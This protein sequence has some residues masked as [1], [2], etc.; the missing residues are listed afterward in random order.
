MKYG[1]PYVFRFG[2]GQER[3]IVI[4][5]TGVERN[6]EALLRATM[7]ILPEAWHGAILSYG[8]VVYNVPPKHYPD[9]VVVIESG[10]QP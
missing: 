8:M 3:A 9:G 5:L 10:L 7:R 1:L 6:A 2:I 4:D